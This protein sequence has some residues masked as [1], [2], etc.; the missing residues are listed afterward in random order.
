MVNHHHQTSPFG[1]MFLHL[2]SKSKRRFPV[3]PCEE[4]I[5]PQKPD[6]RKTKS[7]KKCSKTRDRDGVLF[8]D[9]FLLYIRWAPIPVLKGVVTSINGPYRTYFTPFTP[10]L[11]GRGPR[12]RVEMCTDHPGKKKHEKTTITK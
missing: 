5:G 11:P 3:E 10:I 1:R 8:A 7:Q 12:C 4:V 6:P 9:W 2:T